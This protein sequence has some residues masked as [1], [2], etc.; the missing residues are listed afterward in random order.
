MHNNLK[1]VICKSFDD[2]DKLINI[3]K[4][5]NGQFVVASDDIR[6]HIISKKFS[7]V[8]DAKWINQ[9]YTIND[10]AEEVIST[11][12][13]TNEWMKKKLKSKNFSE[14]L[15][16]PLHCEGGATSQL[17]LDYYLIE[18][19]YNFLLYENN[20]QELI[21]IKDGSN[22]EVNLIISIAKSK[23]NFRVSV[24][25]N[26]TLYKALKFIWIKFR[27]FILALKSTLFILSIKIRNLNFKRKRNFNKSVGIQ[28][29]GNYNNHLE[30]S[31]LLY[32]ELKKKKLNTL[33]ITWKLFPASKQL[34][35]EE[36]SYVELEKYVSI[37]TIL[38]IWL[39]ILILYTKILYYKSEFVVNNRSNL[40]SIIFRSCIIK[41][42]QNYL[43]DEF[44]DKA[45]LK[46]AS[47][48]FFSNNFVVAFK[49]F[50][51][52]ESIVYSQF[53]L[54]NPSGIVFLN[55]GWPYNIDLKIKATEQPIPKSELYFF[56]CS[57]L[58]KE[59]LINESYNKNK[60]EIVGLHW[61]ESLIS[62]KFNFTKNDSRLFL[63]LPPKKIYILLDLNTVLLG[64]NTNQEQHI[65][66]ET[67]MHFITMNENA[68]LIIKPHPATDMKIVLDI[69]SEKEIH[70]YKIIDKKSLPYHSIN[71]ADILVTKAS[72]I[73]LQAMY[74]DVPSIVFNLDKDEVWNIYDKA[75]DYFYARHTLLLFL[76][77]I[78]NDDL[79]RVKW[80]EEKLVQ[81]QNYLNLHGI[82]TYSNPNQ[83]IASKISNLITD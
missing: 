22:W 61:L 82:P 77:K 47:K 34:E 1:L 71:A 32:N 10:V 64:Y 4:R 52:I 35:N 65:L 80:V 62:F 19:S 20:Y 66:L 54:F 53:K 68:F 59:M 49:P 69:L 60:I 3:L 55:G 8:L 11:I 31:I 72:T 16:W 70:N 29:I 14:I 26:Y 38:K 37:I 40:N 24:I 48:N 67:M 27:S 56:A 73:A 46:I 21:L 50:S 41:A 23:T 76:E 9:L 81:H 2:K 79:Y 58:Q 45:I 28:I 78:L 15:N 13:L 44:L 5:K 18:K 63:E 33:L 75:V 83:I 12:N 39:N 51:R 57:S 6:I 74:L 36:I 42:V 25:S 43:F 7:N 17:V 30:H